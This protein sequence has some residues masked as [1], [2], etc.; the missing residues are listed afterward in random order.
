M[1]NTCFRFLYNLI[2]ILIKM[3]FTG[4]N[5]SGSK[6]H[7]LSKHTLLN[8]Q[9]DSTVIFG[10]NIQSDGY[11][12]IVAGT[13]AKLSI[14]KGTY[15]NTGCV[16]SSMKEINIGDNCMFGPNVMIFDNN[17]KF[18]KD[19]GVSYEHTCDSITIGNNCWIASN[20]MIQKGS[21]I[22]DNCVIGA[23]CVIKHNIPSG[24]IV[25]SHVEQ[26][27]HKIEDR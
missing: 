17:H 12:R 6:F 15:F 14:G 1:I 10:K 26:H 13:R 2:R 4:V 19:N 18:D 9:K 22:G 8:F 5:F 11:C 23:G 7:A 16:V 25:T 21:N 24:S 20:V 27:I 3:I